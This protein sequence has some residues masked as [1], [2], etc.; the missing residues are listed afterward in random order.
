MIVDEYREGHIDDL[1]KYYDEF[2]PMVADTTRLHVKP[3]KKD[4]VEFYGAYSDCDFDRYDHKKGGRALQYHADALFTADELR[5]AFK[6]V[7][8]TGGYN[9]FDEVALEAVIKVFGDEAV[10]QP[11]RE[12]SVCIYVHL[13]PHQ[14]VWFDNLTAAKADEISLKDNVVRL[15]WD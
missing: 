9:E 10:Y 4:F 3:T 1:D 13:G 6:L 2:K 5:E 7:T 14:H 15:W 11:A 12:Y 8:D